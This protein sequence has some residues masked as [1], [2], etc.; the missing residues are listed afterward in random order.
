VLCGAATW[1]AARVDA[2]T[3]R[4][5]LTVAPEHVEAPEGLWRI[6][7]G[8]LPVLPP[9]I[10]LHSELVLLLVPRGAPPKPAHKEETVTAELHGLRLLPAA[11]V[12]PLGATLELKN[13]DHVPHTIASQAPND[14]VLLPRAIPAGTSRSERMQRPG[15]FI[16]TDDEL[17]HLRGFLIVTEGGIALRA[18]EHGAIH[19]DVPDGAYTMKLFAHGAFVSERDLD[20]GAHPIELA[21]TVPARGK[22]TTSDSTTAAHPGAAPSAGTAH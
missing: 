16:L 19:A 17:P 6:D 4:V 21:L 12:V 3:V 9:P 18:D 15:V 8:V 13:N 11:V 10:D 20:V 5:Q 2:G 14:A 1:S 22:A 7:N